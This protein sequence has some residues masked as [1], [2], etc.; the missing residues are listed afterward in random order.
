[1]KIKEKTTVGFLF[2]SDI[3]MFDNPASKESLD[4]FTHFHNYYWGENR[5]KVQTEGGRKCS[6]LDLTSANLSELNR[7]SIKILYIR[8]EY[9]LA[10]NAISTGMSPEERVVFL[11]TGQPG[12]GL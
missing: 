12:T 10:Y 6:T 7:R 8:D 9:E 2:L 4:K 11:L 3:H 5:I 1:L